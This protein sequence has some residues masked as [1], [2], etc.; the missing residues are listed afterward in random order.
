MT[1]KNA[2]AASAAVAILTAFAAPAM[3]TNHPEQIRGRYEHGDIDASSRAVN[4]NDIRNNNANHNA[5]A[6]NNRNDNRNN[7]AN[8][9]HNANVNANA[10]LNANKNTNT[11]QGGDGGHAYAAGGHSYAAGGSAT[12]TNTN[13]ADNSS[14]AAGGSAT[15]ANTNSADNSSYAA[16]G[17]ASADNNGNNNGNNNSSS[18]NSQTQSQSQSVSAQSD[19]SNSNNAD[20][21]VT[22]NEN[23]QRAPVSTA[24]AA[25]LAAGEDTCM[26]SSSFGA[27]AVTFGLSVG[28]TWRDA[29]CRRLK[30]S[31][32]LV[33]LG[34]QRAATA[35]MCV[36]E[37][38]RMA[39]EEAGTPCPSRN[40]APTPV[41][42]SYSA[43]APAP[44][45]PTTDFIVHFE[46]DRSNLNREAIEIIDAAAARARQCN[47]SAAVVTGHTDTSGS[48][49][50]NA[51]LSQRR[52]SIVRE[53]LIAR[54]IS[55]DVIRSDARGETDLARFTR[56]GV[57]EP[58][59]RR[60]AVTI[61]F[62]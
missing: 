6:N 48:N 57:R 4:Q 61:S 35:L 16:G 50:Y 10:N 11:A 33:N 24:F 43:P 32:Q 20:Q 52:A 56:N 18:S 1:L 30:N 5:N 37:D 28:T 34:Y 45:C 3:A 41:A 49:T 22:I 27:Q 17:S 12:N 31:R 26:G 13:S 44:I 51:S 36:D 40:D 29:N 42:A 23:Y 39:M 46:W 7:N 47:V 21:N 58:A 62:R 55:A 8:Q 54:G 25:P 19:S 14:H 15:N 9:N 60:A 59:N 38:V 2:F 53:A